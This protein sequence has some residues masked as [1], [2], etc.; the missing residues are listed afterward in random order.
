MEDSET[1]SSSEYQALSGEASPPPNDVARGPVG[2]PLEKPR[3]DRPIQACACNPEKTPWWKSLIELI[4]LAA[5]VAYTGAAYMQLGMM[6]HTYLEMQKQTKEI[7]KQSKAA[8]NAATAAQDAAKSARAANENSEQFF[9]TDERAW[10]EFDSLKPSI[11]ASP[12]PIF[13]T[14]YK[15][16]L[17]PKNVGKTLARN[18]VIRILEGASG[19]WKF[20]QDGAF[21]RHEQD[22]L[23]MGKSRDQA[24]K[25]IVI[26]SDPIPK[27]LAPSDSSPVPLILSGPP[28]MHSGKTVNY[29]YLL[30]R[31]DYVD[32]FNVPH[33]K[34][35]C[36]V[37]FDS[38]G[39]V[40]DCKYGNDEDGNRE[41]SKRRD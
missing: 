7:Q 25:R 24:G 8:T 14:I 20:G 15:Y 1:K 40:E 41:Y 9:R 28:P 27:V 3:A 33:W 10:V 17:V 38:A 34:K 23:M 4:A 32:E 19:T 13:G 5:V 16:E 22:V 31:I 11:L 21:I 18:I 36:F 26:E 39:D 29:G 35:F 12:V 30:G 2:N 37:I 6:N